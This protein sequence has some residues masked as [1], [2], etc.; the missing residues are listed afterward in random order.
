MFSVD[1][2][3]INTRHSLTIT[4]NQ[5]LAMFCFIRRRQD[6][7][8]FCELFRDNTIPAALPAHSKMVR[9]SQPSSVRGGVRLLLTCSAARFQ[10]S[11]LTLV[12]PLHPTRRLFES[13]INTA[14]LQAVPLMQGHFNKTQQPFCV[15][16]IYRK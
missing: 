7:Y 9:A 16:L 3:K 11:V 5:Q 10:L 14:R 13:G 8:L 6:M 15:S 1:Y 2:S 12:L 4:R